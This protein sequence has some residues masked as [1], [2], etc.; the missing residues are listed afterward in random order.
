MLSRP[1]NPTLRPTAFTMAEMVLV[2]ATIAVLA[3]IAIPRYAGAI[4]RYRVDMAA[5]RVVADLMLARSV[6]RST[7]NGQVMDFSTPANGYTL[8]GYA[9]TDGRSGDYSLKLSDEPYKVSLGTVAFGS[10]ASTSVRFTRY[11]TPEAGGSVTV[12]SGGY[13]KNILLDATSGKAE[14]Q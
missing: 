8:T 6:A 2:V 10:P 14:I 11:G 9:A 3:A 1:N 5:K 4:N 13:S 7:G 12:S